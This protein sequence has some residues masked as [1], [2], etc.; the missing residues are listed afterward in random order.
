MTDFDDRH[1]TNRHGAERLILEG[2]ET[3][4]L[5]EYERYPDPAIFRRAIGSSEVLHQLYDRPGDHLQFD[6]SDVVLISEPEMHRY[7]LGSE[8]TRP[9]SVPDNGKL[10]PDGTLIRAR[11]G[12]EIAI[13]TAGGHR[14]PFA[15][16]QALLNLG[17]RLENVVAVDDYDAYPPLSAAV[18]RLR[19][20]GNLR[21]SVDGP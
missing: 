3:I 14:K 1:E 20:P 13:V 11:G 18:R 15:S 5:L 8:I 4:Y 21:I 17:Y 19:P 6:R 16:E 2:M 7:P 9:R 12:N 10:Q